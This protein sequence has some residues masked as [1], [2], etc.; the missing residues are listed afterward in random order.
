MQKEGREGNMV[1]YVS[2]FSCWKAKKKS[3]VKRKRERF[4]L[5]LELLALFFE[6]GNKSSNNNNIKNKEQ[7]LSVGQ[8]IFLPVE[9]D[10]TEL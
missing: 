5:D 9:L 3:R 8:K 4:V 1:R 10:T 6:V 7:V 2:F